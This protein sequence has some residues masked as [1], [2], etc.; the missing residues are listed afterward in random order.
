MN[1][2]AE[3]QELGA[4]LR[5]R[6]PIILIETHEEPRILKLLQQASNLEQQVI[7]RW[8]IVD[9][10]TRNGRDDPIYSTNNLVDALKHI[11]KT[12]QNGLYVLCDAHP[13]LKDPVCV[14]LIREI[15]LEH[16]KSART[17]VFV[18]PKLEELP[19][20]LLRLAAHF[21]PQLPSRDDIRAILSEEAQ[22]WHSQTGEKARGDRAIVEQITLHLMGLEQEDVRRLVRQALR[23]DGEINADDLR[24]VLTTKH[25]ALGGAGALGF[26]TSKVRFDAV[27]GLAR[28]KHWVSL[29]RAPLIESA[30]AG[31]DDGV[32]RPKG[33]VL[34][35]VQGG[36]KSLAARAIAGEWNVPLM[37]LDFGALYNKYY[38]ET[39]RNLRQ[40]F[41]AAEGM[42]PCVL[43]MDEI[44]KGVST[45]SGDQ[46]GG[47]SRR[48][49]G[50]LLTWMSERRKA[51]FV[52]ATANDI[53]QLPP[54]L[55][56]KGRF[57]EI[58]FVDFPNEDA[59][60]Q[61]FGI[62]LRKRGLDPK[63]FDLTPLVAMATGFSGA[64]IEQAVIAASFEARAAQRPMDQ[65]ALVTELQRTRPL[66]VVMA[67][68]VEAL[69]DWAT[70]RAV[71]A[72]DPADDPAAAAQ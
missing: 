52:V 51:V 12:A 31:D 61:I 41:A 34:L 29:R 54:E 40:A 15:A 53:S 42:A 8:S 69:R 66:S 4:L 1:E 65:A 58:F 45:G 48:V 37:R 43:W 38:G 39:E 55:I 57:D 62:H 3:V 47:V 24:R 28:L 70:D 11:D 64:E 6:V 7:F 13:G 56:R 2:R 25:E 71:L 50:S 33:I 49:L 19:S 22:L 10:I 21:R 72:D 17:L 68:R 16:H 26:E 32:D 36:G 30:G 14:R 63:N 59:R 44:E 35:G 67:E 5:S 27:G 20:E 60:R 9:G 46:D 18:S 23:A